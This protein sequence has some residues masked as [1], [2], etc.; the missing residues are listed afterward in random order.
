MF[1]L[2]YEMAE[3][4]DF[5]AHVMATVS[6]LRTLLQSKGAITVN[7]L[8]AVTAGIDLATHDP[9]DQQ[10]EEIEQE[11]WARKKPIH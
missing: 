8:D 11:I 7:D 2:R 10:I 4:Q 9:F 3:M 1:K 6:G 5:H